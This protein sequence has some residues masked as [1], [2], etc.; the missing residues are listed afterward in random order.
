MRGLIKAPSKCD[1]I[2]KDEWDN[3]E[4]SISKRFDAYC[5]I[6]MSGFNQGCEVLLSCSH[7]FHQNCLQ[8]LEK[9]MKTGN[10]SCPICRTNDYQKKITQKGSKAYEIRNLHLIIHLLVVLFVDVNTRN[11]SFQIL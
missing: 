8:A 3:I 6:C 7:I 10:K 5:P 9:Y 4:I 2:T 1:V 11:I